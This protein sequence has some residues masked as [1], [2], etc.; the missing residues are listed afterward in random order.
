V[1]GLRNIT[2]IAAG[3]D[4]LLALNDAA[5]V[6]RLGV[7]SN[8]AEVGE[9]DWFHTHPWNELWPHNRPH[10][11]R[12]KIASI[13]ATPLSAFGV[14]RKGILWS[15]GD[16]GSNKLAHAEERAARFPQKV[17]GLTDSRTKIVVGSPRLT[18]A[19]TED[20]SAYIWGSLDDAFPQAASWDLPHGIDL[21][22]NEAEGRVL[23]LKPA[24]LQLPNVCGAAVGDEHMVIVTKDGKVYSWGSNRSGQCGLGWSRTSLSMPYELKIKNLDSRGVKWVAA[25]GTWT[26]FGVPVEGAGRGIT[27][28]IPSKQKADEMEVK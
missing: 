26:F 16:N 20:G 4:F 19:V 18:L 9:V 15:W 12:P 7:F 25:A 27:T 2:S 28:S 5:E 23:I 22:Q 24:K 13:H 17:R 14:D 11:T 21:D 8:D 10:S 1:I 3:N 6:Q